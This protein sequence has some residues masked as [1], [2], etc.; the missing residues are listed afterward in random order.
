MSRYG[1][2]RELPGM[3]WM[4]CRLPAARSRREDQQEQLDNPVGPGEVNLDGSWVVSSPLL[5]QLMFGFRDA[6][7]PASAVTVCTRLAIAIYCPL[8]PN[9]LLLSWS[10][11]PRIC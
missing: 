5:S 1:E 8:H 4:E 9:F 3:F 10:E 2:I 11:R 6:G 7:R